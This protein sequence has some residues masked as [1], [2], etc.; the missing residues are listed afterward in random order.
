MILSYRNHLNF[1]VPS[2][3]PTESEDELL[4]VTTSKK[5][6]DQSLNEHCAVL[7]RVDASPKMAVT[8]LK[9][10]DETAIAHRFRGAGHQCCI[11]HVM[12]FIGGHFNDTIKTCRKIRRVYIV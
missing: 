10:K 6:D 2:V 4:H 8:N 1:I 3:R 5:G 11:C 7:R 12:R 9:K